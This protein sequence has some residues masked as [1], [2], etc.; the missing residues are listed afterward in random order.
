[1]LRYKPWKNK[2]DDAWENQVSSDD[3]FILQWKRF[4]QT[5]F[6]IKHVP[7][8]HGK[9]KDIQSLSDIQQSENCVQPEQ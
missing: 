7:D 6:A 8:W 3:V 9:L 4:L 2:Q 5:N 1:L